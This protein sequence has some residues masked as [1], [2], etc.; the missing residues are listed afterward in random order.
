MHPRKVAPKPA[1]KPADRRPSSVHTLI[2]SDFAESRVA[3]WDSVTLFVFS[4][5]FFL[6]NI[7]FPK[8]KNFD[9]FHYIPSA[10]QW[11]AGSENQNWE[12]PP[13]AKILI[14]LGIRLFGDVPLGWRFMSVVFGAITV[15]GMYR[16]AYEL[17]GKNRRAAWICTGITVFN[18]LL[19]V[20]ARIAMLDTFMMGFLV[21]SLWGFVRAIDPDVFDPRW[22]RLSGVFM[23]LAIACKWFALVPYLMCGALL[24][25]QAVHLK[26]KNRV[27]D[28]VLYWAFVPALFYFATFMPYL[29]V[30]R[31]PPYTVLELLTS[32]QARMLDGQKRVVTAHPYMSQFWDWIWL[33]RP[34]WYAFDKEG[35]DQKTVRG[36]LLLGN[37]LIMWG[38]LVAIT[39]MVVR[40]LKTRGRTAFLILYFYFGFALCWIVI[41][42]K[43]AFYY[44]YYPAGMMLSLAWT[45]WLQKTKKNG[46]PIVAVA[47]TFGVFFYFFPILSAMPIKGETFVDWMW[48]QSWI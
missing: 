29:W 35:V 18:Q 36:V 44:Y 2:K 32:H 12:H 39:A 1:L 7:S 31:N 5:I 45:Y 22:I 16:L 27:V 30:N 43:V 37:P 4:L 6:L 8:T 11:I 20:Q 47:A 3:F 19:Y 38:G 25:A 21:W 13:L 24:I 33:K 40:F 23:G 14:S 42:R 34:I 9:E 41:P 28:L 26:S 48:L 10:L 15:V 17:F 46:I